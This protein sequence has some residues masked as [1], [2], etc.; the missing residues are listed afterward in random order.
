MF[1]V[2]LSDADRLKKS[3][4]M[5]Q[6]ILNGKFTPNSNNRNTHWKST[7]KGQAFR[8]SWEALYACLNETAEY[9]TLR[10]SYTLDDREFVYI[11]DFIDHD[12][13]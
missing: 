3:V 11:V 1:G 12:K 10:I 7:Y 8:S 9:E 13:K 6:L 4:I 5:K 2:K